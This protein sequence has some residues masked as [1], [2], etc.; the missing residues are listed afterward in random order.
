MDTD[1]FI[2]FKMRLKRMVKVSG[3][4]VYPTQVE[5]TLRQHQAVR[6]VCVVGV[7]IPTR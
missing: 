1:G 6:D 7:P 2:Y 4:A 5:E 3:M